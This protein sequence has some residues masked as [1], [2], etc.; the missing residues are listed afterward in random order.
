M[1]VLGTWRGWGATLAGMMPIPRP[2][3]TVRRASLATGTD[4][5]RDLA[6]LGIVAPKRRKG[7]AT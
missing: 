2:Q 4:A 1:I 3:L 6:R 5:R 7:R